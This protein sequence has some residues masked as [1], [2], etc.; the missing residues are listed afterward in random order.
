MTLQC[1]KIEESASESGKALINI[2]NKV[3]TSEEKD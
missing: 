2:N 3:Q 1:L